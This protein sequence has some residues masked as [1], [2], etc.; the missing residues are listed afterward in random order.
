MTDLTSREMIEL[1]VRALDRNARRFKKAR[2]V[3]GKRPAARGAKGAIRTATNPQA[4]R[5]TKLR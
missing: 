4:N 5:N 2:P 3:P 1:A